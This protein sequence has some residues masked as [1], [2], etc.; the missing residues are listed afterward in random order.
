MNLNRWYSYVVDIVAALI[1]P[2]LCVDTLLLFVKNIFVWKVKSLMVVLIDEVKQ[3]LIHL[4]FSGW[5]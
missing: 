5:L 3:M 1:I 2:T 4:K